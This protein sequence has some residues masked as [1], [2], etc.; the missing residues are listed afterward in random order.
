MG[1]SGDNYDV[2][3][4]SG[5]KTVEERD[6]A[7]RPASLEGKAIAELWNGSFRGDE[8]FSVVEQ[9]MGQEYPGVK[10]VNYQEF[11]SI[12]TSDEKHLNAVLPGQFGKH[13]IDAVIAATGC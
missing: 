8:I 1:N 5:K 3:W 4:P 2:V 6:F 12:Q 11:E 10:F 7:P 13:K 9:E